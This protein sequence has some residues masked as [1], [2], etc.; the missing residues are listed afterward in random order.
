MVEAL[1]HTIGNRAIGIQRGEHNV[2][3]LHQV[4]Q[5]SYIENGFLLSC[6]GRVRQIFSRRR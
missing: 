6:E 2:D 3:G 4:I 5:A 1:M